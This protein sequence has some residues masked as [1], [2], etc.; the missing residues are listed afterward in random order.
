MTI[1]LLGEYKGDTVRQRQTRIFSFYWGKG[2][3]RLK[4]SIKGQMQEKTTAAASSPFW[5]TQATRDASPYILLSSICEKQVPL[6][7]LSSMR[8]LTAVH[9]T[10]FESK[11]L[12]AQV[13]LGCFYSLSTDDQHPAS[14]S[15]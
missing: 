3:G 8:N 5:R 11:N 9:A 4:W 10:E 15:L 12:E 14:L 1:E 6:E 2:T 13:E 7:N